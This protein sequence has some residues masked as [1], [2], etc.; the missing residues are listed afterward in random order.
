[1]YQHSDKRRKLTEDDVRTILR[2]IEDGKRL[3]Y[4]A[5]RFTKKAIASRFGI[6]VQHL[7]DIV[8]GKYWKEV[9][10]ECN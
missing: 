7:H 9:S 6:S 4:E 3:S 10:N 8:K 2:Q 1:M 5:G